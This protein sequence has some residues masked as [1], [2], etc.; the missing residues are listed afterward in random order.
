MS[1]YRYECEKCG[2]ATEHQGWCPEKCLICEHSELEGRV[3]ALSRQLAERQ[4]REV[5][6]INPR[7]NEWDW[8]ILVKTGEGPRTAKVS[9]TGVVNFDNEDG[10][11]TDPSEWEGWMIIHE[12][13]LPPGPEGEGEV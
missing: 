9:E 8:T 11:A 3:A 7:W 12:F 10:E 4:W 6:S 13:K 1:T 5:D 2:E